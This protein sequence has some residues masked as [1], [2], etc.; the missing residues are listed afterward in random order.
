VAFQNDFGL[1][2]AFDHSSDLQPKASKKWNISLMEMANL[3]N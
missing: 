1:R 2:T 3:P